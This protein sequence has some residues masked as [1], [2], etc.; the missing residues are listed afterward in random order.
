MPKPK[1]S[2]SRV[3][4]STNKKSSFRFRWWM[5][6]VL[7]VLV[8]LVGVLVLRFSNASGGNRV[9]TVGNGLNPGGGAQIVNASDGYVA[10]SQAV[11]ALNGEFAQANERY[12][13]I[14]GNRDPS[15]IDRIDLNVCAVIYRYSSNGSPITYSF[16]L[17]DWGGNQMAVQPG[18]TLYGAGSVRICI[19]KTIRYDDNNNNVF[20]K[21]VVT[22]PQSARIAT[23]ERSG[24]V[25][26]R[27]SN[28][29]PQPQPAP[30]PAPPPQQQQCVN[31]STGTVTC[32]FPAGTLT[33]TCGYRNVNGYALVC[34][35]GNW[36]Y[37]GTGDVDYNLARQ[38]GATHEHDVGYWQWG[39][40]CAVKSRITSEPRLDYQS[41]NHFFLVGC[42]PASAFKSTPSSWT[43][44]RVIAPEIPKGRLYIT[45][46]GPNGPIPPDA[47]FKSSPSATPGNTGVCVK[48]NENSTFACEGKNPWSLDGLFVSGSPYRAYFTVPNNWKLTR[49]LVNK[50]QLGDPSTSVQVNIRQNATTYVDLYFD[51][52]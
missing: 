28:P 13:D 22:S 48:N 25:Y 17:L 4:K 31:G 41:P 6:L 27:S 15:T 43:Q 47:R 33:S 18:T 38:R 46:Y 42:P 11:S 40:F 21:F 50:E 49:V 16:E 26:F 12:G 20:Y 10:V 23:I 9:F 19:P 51:P 36:N 30:G 2:K 37:I 3:A 32:G 35:Q 44:G 24:T 1:P 45:K 39:N 7:V 34:P 29:T 5:G 14:I 8:A 52:K